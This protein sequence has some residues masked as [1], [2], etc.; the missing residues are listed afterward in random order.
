MRINL[1]PRTER[2]T[3]EHSKEK[4]AFWRGIGNGEALEIALRVTNENKAQVVDA[5]KSMGTSVRDVWTDLNGHMRKVFQLSPVQEHLSAESRQKISDAIVTMA[6][7]LGFAAAGVQGAAGL[8]KLGTGVEKGD[9]ARMLDGSVDV[10]TSAAV[11]TTVAG[12]STAPLILGPLA[13][14][15]GVSRGV[16]NAIQGYKKGDSRQEIQGVLDATRS[17]GV[18]GRLLSSHSATLGT[19]AAVLGPIAGVIGVGRGY[20]DL[21]TGLQENSKTK[22]LQGLTDIAS[23]IGLTMA[24]TGLGTVPGIALAVAAIGTRAV[25]S[26]SEKFQARVDRQLDKMA[27]ALSS[28]TQKIDSFVEPVLVSARPIIEKWFGWEK[29]ENSSVSEPPPMN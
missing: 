20:Y 6:K 28:T 14:G 3:P 1:A 4:P 21:T 5:F 24:T 11:A 8:Y 17:A 9:K 18:F 16:V 2:K 22:Q 23:S 25:Y 19:V 7:G 15:L 10:T 29:G 27:P 12:L 26:V 13:A